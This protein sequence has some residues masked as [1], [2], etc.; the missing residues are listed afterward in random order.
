MKQILYFLLVS[1]FCTVLHSQDKSVQ[2]IYIFYSNDLQAGIGQQ[3]AVFM[4]P[5]FP[6]VLGGGAAVSGILEDYR[7]KAEDNGDIV[8][9]LDAGDIFYSSKPIGIE[10]NGLAVIDYM[11][12]IGY[13]AMAPGNHDF[14]LGRD[15]FSKIAESAAFPVLA[16]NLR[17]SDNH[18]GPENLKTH[19]LIQT[20]GLQI[21]LFGIVSKSAE[22]ND[23]PAAVEGL[24][25]SDEVPAAKKA[26]ESLKKDGADLIIA[27]VHL[28][29][30]YDAEEGYLYI[31]QSR[32]QNIENNSY[33]NAMELAA[34][35]PGIDVLVSGKIHRGYQEPWE[36]PANH[37]ICVQNYAN[38]G[39]LGLM[40]LNINKT[41]KKITG[42]EL[43][44]ADGGLLLLSED[45]FWPEPEM[46]QKIKD[47]QAE[48]EEGFDDI[49]GITTKTISRSSNGES[50]MGNL[51]CDAMLEAGKADF[52]FNNFSGMRQDLAIG[53]ITPRKI[54][55][56][57]PFGNEIVVVEMKGS[58]I[59][60][61][62][63]GS[64]RGTYSGLAIGGGKIEYDDDR[65]DG[66]KITLFEIAGSE[67]DPEKTY[68]TAM[69]EYLAEGNYGMNKLAY[70]P[71]EKFNYTG[72]IVKEAVV[73]YIRKNSPLNIETDGRWKRK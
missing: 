60:D 33:V 44:S 57:F 54:A 11:N 41:S 69:T 61:L 12:T 29:L 47:L 5:D 19:T 66:S 49:I 67:L 13:D 73:N 70:L 27:L 71:D 10:S 9:L 52:V 22:L 24:I 63:E 58:L 55:D 1:I 42:Y 15:A 25:F 2:K 56:V 62:L 32:K 8:L 40:I 14:D 36:D 64:V 48:Y 6:P 35:V 3:K 7:E 28:G 43:P 45:E 26:V 65:P 20:G 72:I 50:P 31:E 51:M 59:L 16:A 39:N 21:G 34:S 53:G 18:K 38:G 23:D 68:K 30:P 17:Y 4:N 37:T 46:A